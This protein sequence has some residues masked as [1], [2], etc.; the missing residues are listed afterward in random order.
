MVETFE[1]KA[2]M[3]VFKLILMV[4]QLPYVSRIPRTYSSQSHKGR[5]PCIKSIVPTR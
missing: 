3:V 1:P 4:G 5:A 2:K